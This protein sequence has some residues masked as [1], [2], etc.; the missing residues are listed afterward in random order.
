MIVVLG[1]LATICW[2]LFHI[3]KFSIFSFSFISND[4][5]IDLLIDIKIK[6]ETF[7][8]F[9]NCNTVLIC[10]NLQDFEAFK[11]YSNTLLQKEKE[12]NERL[13]HLAEWPLWLKDIV[14]PLVDGI[15]GSYLSYTKCG[16]ND[17]NL[18]HFPYFQLDD[19]FHHLKPF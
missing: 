13:R 12:I 19:L 15:L 2:I 16:K 9:F 10:F 14:I 1:I 4:Q 6:C 5:K 3:S 7:M 11:K 8:S 17:F 18:N